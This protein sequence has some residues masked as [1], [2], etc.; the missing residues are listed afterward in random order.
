[1]KK[2]RNARLKET[3]AMLMIGDC[4]LGIVAPE[5]HVRLWE[6][7]PQQ[8]RRTLKGLV[9]RPNLTRALSAAGL[10]LITWWALRQSSQSFD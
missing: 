8:L 2:I 7:G 5:Q 4:I 10:V 6:V 9:E 3:I 1:M